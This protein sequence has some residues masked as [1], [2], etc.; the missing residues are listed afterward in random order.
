MSKISPFLWFNTEAEE[1]ATLY[2][3]LFP[4]SR[5]VD[6][7]RQDPAGP[8]FVVVFELDGARVSALNGGPL[9]ATFTEAISFQ[10]DCDDQAEVDRY[11]DAL[12]A[13]GGEPGNCGWLKDR[14]GL[15]WQIVPTA[16]PKLLADPDREAAAR[17]MTAMLA[18]NKIEIAALEAAKAG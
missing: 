2:T 7:Q 9:H 16:L 14:Y 15:S 12:T 13:D 1:A 5:I 11:W 18:M 8:A 17:V 4:N 3:R 10:V 6:V